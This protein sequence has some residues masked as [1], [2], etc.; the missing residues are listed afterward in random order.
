VLK[1]T[2]ITSF[3][4]LLPKA[5]QKVIV[6]A[7]LEAERY[8]MKTIQR[9]AY[10]AKLRD[11]RDKQII[12]VVTGVRRCGKS[13]LLNLFQQELIDGGVPKEQVT[14]INFE[15]VSSSYNKSWHDVYKEIEAKLIPNKINYIFLD[16]I[17][18]IAEFERLLTG[19][20]TR[21]NVDLYVTGSN[22]HILSSEL[23]TLLTG[24]SFE[25]SLLPLSFKEYLSAFDD[26][27]RTAID[28]HFTDY[29]TYGGFPQALEIFMTNPNRVDEYL[30]GVFNMIIMRDI[31]GRGKVTDPVTLNKITRFIYDNIGNFSS[32]NKIAGVLGMSHHTVAGYIEAL[33]D[34]FLLY[35]V[36][37]LSIKGKEQLQTQDKL[38]AVDLGFRSMLLGR[39]AGADTGHMLE[40]VVYLELL[41]RGG[42]VWVGKAGNKEVDFVVQDE[43]GYTSYYQVSWTTNDEN[44]LERELAPLKAIK[45]HSPKSLIT[46]DNDE[47]TYNGIRKLNIVNWLTR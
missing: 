29:L 40:N 33:T 26:N 34:S 32:S 27:S 24:R 11:M 12:K 47:P 25:I 38:Y 35:Q 46:T 8:F 15:E 14:Q 13:T 5:L 21:K 17:Q 23:A 36:G 41:R 2:L 43:N 44:T 16:E 4:I 22:A 6:S 10:L 28:K 18:Y 37:R 45:D 31:L 30:S 3:G 39:E 20:H 42:S 9:E 7:I 19:L 1:N